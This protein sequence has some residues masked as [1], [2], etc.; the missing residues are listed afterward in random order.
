MLRVATPEDAG[1]S[2]MID[3]V[4]V[5]SQ[6][7]LRDVA[8]LLPYAKNT[9][10]HSK[11]QVA[12]LAEHI[13]KVGW[14]N[15][16]LVADNGIL[17]GHG[18][19]MAA[20]VL[21]MKRVP[22]IDLSH[23]TPE[24]RRAYVIWDNR[25][26]EKSSWDLPMLKMETDDL[27]ELGLDIEAST[28]FSEVDLA[29]L[30]EGIEDPKEEGDGDAD[31]VPDPPAVPKSVLGDVWV[32]SPHRVMCGSSTDPAAWQRLMDGERADVC[33]TD[34]PYNVDIGAKNERLD[35]ADGGNR[36][37][38]GGIAN[39]K[40][41]DDVFRAFLLSMYGCVFDVLKPGAAI[42][43]AHADVEGLNFRSTFREAGFKLQSCIIWNKN[44]MVLGRWDFQPKHE[45]ILYG[46]K[47]G[48]A[49]KW[50]G[51]RKQTT[52]IEMGEGGPFTL[53]PDG[54]WQIKVG[55]SV[56]VVE[57]SATVQEHLS[58]VLYEPKPARSDL[59]PTQKPVALV[60]RMLRNS[61]R[62]GDIAVD[63][64]GGSGTTLIAADRLGLCARLMELDPKF[65]D[66]IVRR[67]E[68]YTGRRAVH[69]VTGLPFPAEDEER[70]LDEAA[71]TPEDDAPF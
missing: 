33:W 22:A 56:L 63:A 8:E 7:A 41:A 57:G 18:R 29:K 31:D 23:L 45:P 17:A 34:P 21:G 10:A 67:W 27:R 30:L 13:R 48:S 38:T 64:F 1:T 20:H 62:P 50:F 55:D 3:G 54:R 28:G 68:Q 66:V 24:E 2:Q 49:H 65:A 61:S 69:A 60:E 47:P 6:F 9:R 32:C 39:D 40:Q 26:A 36:K 5:P 42:Y 58:T 44:Q 11:A 71:A 12:E 52:V 51:G 15:P 14:T 19:I 16:V 43:V 25:S 59:H 35:E 37:K 70:S 46:W 4:R 53:M